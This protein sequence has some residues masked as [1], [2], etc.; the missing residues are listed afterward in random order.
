MDR[1]DARYKIFKEKLK[2][3]GYVKDSAKKVNKVMT[4]KTADFGMMSDA[5]NKKIARA[6][7]QAK[8][9]KD[10]RKRIEKISTMAG[11]KYSE[12]QE[13]EVIQRAISALDDNAMGSQA[14]AD[15]NVMVQLGNFKDLTKD[16]EISTNDNKKTK[17]KRDDAVK[18][19]DTLMKVKAP[20]RTKYIQLLQKDS[21]SFK[22]TFNSV[23]SVANRF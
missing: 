22:K 23:L 5:G 21:K 10:L 15:K 12:A 2:K 19:Y 11:G 9:E 13:D 17:V 1:V 4:E 14:W 7:A 8:D 18:V 20:V 6:V 16:G 3:L